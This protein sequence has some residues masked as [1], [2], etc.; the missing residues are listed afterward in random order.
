MKNIDKLNRENFRAILETLSCPGDLRNIE[1]I[2]DSYICGFAS[3]LC[4]SEVSLCNKTD[5]NFD[6]IL[7]TTNVKIANLNEC[8]Y[9]F[10]TNLEDIFTKVKKGTF[11]NPENSCTIIYICDFSKSYEYNLSGPGIDG[12]KKVKLPLGRK[13]VNEI[14]DNNSVFPLGNEVFF[15]D[16]KT[17]EL[18]ALSRTTKVI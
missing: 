8:D 13:F 2:F 17:G 15:L 12:T 14:M 9:L 18:L 10:C 11:E 4:F 16:A 6:Y 3:V 7:A 1:K 5:E